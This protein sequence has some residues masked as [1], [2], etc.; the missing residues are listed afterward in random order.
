MRANARAGRLRR[1]FRGAARVI[2]DARGPRGHPPWLS[3]ADAGAVSLRLRRS[4]AEGRFPRIHALPLPSSFSMLRRSSIR[5][6][7]PLPRRAKPGLATPHPA[8][9]CRAQPGHALRFQY[10]SVSRPRSSSPRHGLP[11]A[12]FSG[13]SPGPAQPPRR[14]P[15]APA[16]R[17]CSRTGA[18]AGGSA[19]GTARSPPGGRRA[20]CRSP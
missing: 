5:A 10:A 13:A 14:E 11:C 2:S 1:N 20:S 9:P 8:Q 15:R 17:A 4:G 18:R 7:A 3:F 16:S 12:P 6:A 19:S